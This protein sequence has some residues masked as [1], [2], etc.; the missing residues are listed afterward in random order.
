MNTVRPMM[1]KKFETLGYRTHTERRQRL[2][3]IPGHH[4][5]HHFHYCSK[6]DLIASFVSIG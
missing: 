2:E 6:P 1:L 5:L 3:I 4:N